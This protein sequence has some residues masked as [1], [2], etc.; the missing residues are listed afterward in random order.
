MTANL[1]PAIARLRRA[2]AARA[3]GAVR[4]LRACS[5]GIATLNTTSG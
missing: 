1:L 4:E 3:Q 5:D 2:V